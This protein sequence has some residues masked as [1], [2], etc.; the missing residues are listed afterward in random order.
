[1]RDL[2]PWVFIVGVGLLVVL[3]FFLGSLTGWC[4]REF[5]CPRFLEVHPKIQQSPAASD[6]KITAMPAEA[7]RQLPRGLG[8]TD[9]GRVV[10]RAGKYI[11][12][13]CDSRSA[14]PCVVLVIA[15]DYEWTPPDGGHVT[16]EVLP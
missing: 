6:I 3:V 13:S 7:L 14:Y 11:S 9:D 1:M 5:E 10:L 8:V 12:P 15:D 4:L 16:R 2:R